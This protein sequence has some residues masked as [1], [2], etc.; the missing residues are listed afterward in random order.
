MGSG[1]GLG[2]SSFSTSHL[3]A[4]YGSVRHGS[5]NV[6]SSGHDN[7][8]TLNEYGNKSIDKLLNW[9]TANKLAIHPGKSRYMIFKPPFVN[10]D[11]LPRGSNNYPYFP[12]FLNMNNEGENDISK[13]N[14]VKGIPNESEKSL[15]VLG[16]LFDQHLNLQDHAKSIHSKVSRNIYMLNQVK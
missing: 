9:Y 7:L 16:V 13:I 1:R 3:Q 2:V 6:E 15:K 11:S 10:L 8:Q 14:L 12:L 4:R 5:M